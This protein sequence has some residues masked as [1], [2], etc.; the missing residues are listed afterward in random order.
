MPP[1]D[2][3]DGYGKSVGDLTCSEEAGSHSPMPL[4]RPSGGSGESG[5]CAV[6]AWV[7]QVGL[8]A[9]WDVDARF[10]GSAAFTAYPAS[11]QWSIWT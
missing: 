10:D 4:L 7:E 2:G 1:Q 11:P 6:P 3:L 9:V 5:G 8:R